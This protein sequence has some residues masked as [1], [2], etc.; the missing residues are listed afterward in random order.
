MNKP[1]HPLLALLS[2]HKAP[3]DVY[4]SGR[5]PLPE[6]VETR[7]TLEQLKQELKAKGEFESY[8]LNTLE[9]MASYEGLMQREI[10]PYAIKIGFQLVSAHEIQKQKMKKRWND[11]KYREEQ[12]QATKKR[13]ENP[14]YREERVEEAFKRWNSSK[15]C[16]NHAKAMA[17]LQ[18]DPEYRANHAKAM[19]ELQKD[20]EYRQT[21]IEIMDK[22]WR[23]PEF[24]KK[25]TEAMAKRWKNPDF[26]KK[27]TEVMAK[28][29]ENPDFRKKH[30]EAMAKLWE[31]PESRLK[32]A[33]LMSQLRKTPEFQEKYTKVMTKLWKDPD[34]RKKQSEGLQKWLAT[35]PKLPPIRIQ[36]LVNR[37]TGKN[38]DPLDERYIPEI[39][40][41]QQC[42]LDELH[43]ALNELEKSDQEAFSV[44]IE[45][46]GFDDVNPE[47]TDKALS[48][49]IDEQ[50]E[51]LYQRGLTFLKERLL[52]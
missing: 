36:G 20:P 11:P 34:F 26:R 44:I 35:Q 10:R 12:S 23:D 33:K 52:P 25:H 3:S 18:K 32:Y 9:V 43:M 45:R 4:F 41:L 42:E 51:A 17:K 24:R 49:Q 8:V 2:L 22:R 21:Q 31:N 46:F 38:I 1:A 5:K 39:L 30:T 15:Y 7:K 6:I 14:K 40:L 19:A 29:W 50:E 48:G 16:K 13:W 47:S 28:L 27:H 37:E